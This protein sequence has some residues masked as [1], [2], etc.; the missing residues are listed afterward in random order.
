MS[1]EAL[2]MESFNHKHIIK[3]INNYAYKEEFYFVMDCAKGGEL[4]QYISK[5]KILSEYISKKIF[6]QIHEAVKYIHSKGIVHRD[7]KPLNI[8]FLDEK[9]EHIVVLYPIYIS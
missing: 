1:R 5:N 7:L 4:K 8:L 6:K 9:Q 3:L 2:Y